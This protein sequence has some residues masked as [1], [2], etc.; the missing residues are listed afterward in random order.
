LIKGQNGRW[1]EIHEGS[2]TKEKGNHNDVGA[3]GAE[4]FGSALRGV[5]MKDVREN[6]SIRNEDGDNRHSNVNGHNNKDY[7]LIHIGSVAG[8]FKEGK[9][10][11]HEM[12]DKVV[13]A[14][15]QTHYASCVGHGSSKSHQ[16]N[17]YQKE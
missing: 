12:I 2:R 13:S 14:E 17:T 7:Q 4:G 6:E 9:D 1:F 16:V 8:E 5:N 11:T 15:G 10:V 3:A